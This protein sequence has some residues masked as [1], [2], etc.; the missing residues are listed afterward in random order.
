MSIYMPMNLNTWTIRICMEKA[1]SN[2]IVGKNGKTEK[3]VLY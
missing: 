2:F 1:L 3:S